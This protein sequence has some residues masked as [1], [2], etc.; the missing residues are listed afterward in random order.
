MAPDTDSQDFSHEGATGCQKFIARQPIFDRQETL[1][2][3][4]LLFRTSLNNY[5]C[6]PAGGSVA[7]HIMDN[8]LLFGIETLTGGRRA[9][10]NF[11]REALVRDYAMLLPSGQVVVEILEDIQPD[12]EVL[13]ACRRLRK[14]GYLIALDDFLTGPD[15]N[16]LTSFASIIKVDFRATPLEE[17]AALVKRYASSGIKLLAEKVETREEINA[18]LQMGYEYFQGYFYC[19]PQIMATRDIP[20]CKINY[21]RMLQAINR[22]ELDFREIDQ[23]L[24][25][26]PSLLYRLLRY[27]NSAN[28]GLRGRVNS[29]RHAL[30][31][32]GEA[33]L[34]K[35]ASVMAI[36]D[37]GSDKPSELIFTSL[38]RARICE[39]LAPRIR[40]AGRQT[41]VFLL[42]LLSLLDVMM[43]RDIRSVLAEIPLADEIKDALL[44]K[45]CRLRC[46]LDSCI[47]QERGDWQR[48]HHCLDRVGVDPEEYQGLYMEAIQ[49]GREIFI[50]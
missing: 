24:H 19:R 14:K 22:P 8:Y 47:A 3:Y 45:C 1:M 37:L 32:L 33:N 29:I 41:D 9:F 49:W 4:E 25:Q 27:L 13:A 12:D 6:P 36:L 26:E 31:L 30:S 15:R 48:L 44:G 34:R 39:L 11:T 18:G 38:V 16:P 23:I 21:L 42:G 17:C 7:E 50:L 20:N 43:E 40:I 5:F 10:L 2:G 46:L 28:F 35:W